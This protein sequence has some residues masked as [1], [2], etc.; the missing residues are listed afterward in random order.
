MSNPIRPGLTKEVCVACN[1]RNRLRTDRHPGDHS[2]RRPHC[3]LR[4]SSL[5][6]GARALS[7]RLARR[8]CDDTGLLVAVDGNGDRRALG[9]A[10]ARSV[11]Q[12]ERVVAVPHE[13]RARARAARERQELLEETDVPSPLLGCDE[14]VRYDRRP[15]VRGLVLGRVERQRGLVVDLEPRTVAEDLDP[16]PRVEAERSRRRHDRPGRAARELEGDDRVLAAAGLAETFVTSPMRKRAR[17][18]MCTVP[19]ASRS[20]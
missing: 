6:G 1:G 5:N 15:H 9:E 17:S 12:L 4:A 16:L 18:N 2:A 20:T 7:L 10:A 8:R 19:D 3:L 11:N 14:R 13:R